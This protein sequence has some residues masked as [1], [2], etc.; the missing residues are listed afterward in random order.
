MSDRVF[1]VIGI[2]LAAF[3]AWQSTLI[4]ESFIQD[5]V[6]PKAFPLIIAIVL[7]LSSLVFILKP[8]PE[9]DW[10]AVGQ[11]FEIG[12]SVA[13][14]VAYAL[15]LPEAGFVASTAVAASFLSWRLGA[16]PLHAI[17]AGIAIAAG[18]YVVFHLILG[19]SLARG[20]WGF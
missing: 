16:A 19:L 10:P 17:P 1:G 8:D 13:L 3:Y 9:P 14:L 4:Q 11:L 7:A 6:G 20:P 12:I 5:P 2:L 18:I 15:A